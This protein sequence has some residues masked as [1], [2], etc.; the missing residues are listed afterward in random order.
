MNPTLTMALLPAALLAACDAPA[1]AGRA[2]PRSRVPVLLLVGVYHMGN[3]G[4]DAHN[5]RADDVRAPK[6]QQ[7]LE[8]LAEGLARFRPTRVAVERKP[9]DAAE[10]DEQYRRYRSGEL[11]L[12]DGEV[13]QIGFRLAARLGLD[14]VDPIDWNEMP[15]MPIEKLDIDAFAARRGLEPRVAAIREEGERISRRQQDFLA[16]HTLGEMLR[17]L[18]SPESLHESHRRYFD[19]AR[20]AEGDEYTGANWVQNWFGRNLK[21]FVNL[22]RLASEGDR[23]AVIF[24]SGH[25]SLLRLFAEQS[26]LFDVVDVA[27]FL[28]R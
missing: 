9:A 14:R 5:V 15:D 10:L 21:I 1:R 24:G 11:A 18:N 6:R 13:H 17:M 8:A 3:P 16:R 27:E 25:V 20:I 12:D 28:P 7:E 23:V 4:R 19:Y 2:A 22:T 26:G